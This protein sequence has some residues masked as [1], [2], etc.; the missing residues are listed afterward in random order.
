MEFSQDPP[1]GDTMIKEE[2]ESLFPDNAPYFINRID[3]RE[4]KIDI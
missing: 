4:K 1:K 3:F 2:Q